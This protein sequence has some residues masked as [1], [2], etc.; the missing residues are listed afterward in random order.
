FSKGEAGKLQLDARPFSLRDCLGD[1]LKTLGPR[2]HQK[3]LELACHVPSEVPDQLVGD[4]LRL[5]QVV[6]NLVGN[7]IKFTEKGEVVVSV[8]SQQSG[9]GQHSTSLTPDP[10]LL[11]PDSVELSFAVR[12]TGVG[13]APD[14]QGPIFEAF[15]QGDSSTTRRFGGT[16]L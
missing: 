8:R 11:T 15:T 4:P 14:K 13:I 6:L 1:A 12:D 16:G 10:C 5:R 2:A 7:A 3:G 9:A